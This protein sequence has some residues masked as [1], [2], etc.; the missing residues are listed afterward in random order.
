MSSTNIKKASSALA[1]IDC[2]N[3]FVSCER[4][5]RP[6]ISVQP[7][8]VLSSND[9]CIISRSNE[10]KNLGI[11]MGAP[12]FKYRHLFSRR[13]VTVF[14]ANFELYGDIS[15]R[16]I[17]LLANTAPNIEIY[18]VDES[19][20]DISQL[21]IANYQKWGEALSDKVLRDV[22]IPVSVGLASSRQLAK[23]AVF[24]AKKT[25]RDSHCISLVGAQ[26]TRL[27][28][29]LGST[30]IDK[31]WGVGPRL[32]RKLKSF[33]VF[34]ALDLKQL[35]RGLAK[36]LMGV[37]GQRLIAEL[38]GTPTTPIGS[39]NKPRQSIMRRRV[40]GAS[41]D[42]VQDISSSLANLTSQATTKLR[43][44]R[45]VANSVTVTLESNPYQPEYVKIQRHIPF[46]TPSADTGM[47]LSSIMR[48]IEQLPHYSK[49]HRISIAMSDLAPLDALQAD[50]LGSIDLD[51]LSASN[52]RMQALDTINNRYAKD[53][54]R[55]AASDLSHAWKPKSRF[56]SPRY[57]SSWQELP[58]AKI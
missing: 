46:S 4:L 45:L 37:H 29:Y 26:D 57:T 22:G 6:D 33:Q 13:D 15:R 27:K 58:V 55:Y 19:F 30:P 44:E 31:V 14:S 52:R 25:P 41:I 10:A 2:D 21:N 23:I 7:V 39:Y 1:L 35:S 34:T 18:S 48:D 47:I 17:E 36:Q 24:H 11:P 40:L 8:V 42:K 38:H 12:A 3:F 20:L 9:G 54:L 56:R 32:S 16:I 50:M 53:T 28:S 51:V 5:F 49:Y 43:Q